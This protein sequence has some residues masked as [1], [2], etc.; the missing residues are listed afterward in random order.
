V[1]PGLR[2]AVVLAALVLTGAALTSAASAHTSASR[3]VDRTY[4]CAT[5]YLG[6]I[7]QVQLELFG[8]VRDPAGG[9]RLAYGEVTTTPNW[10]LAGLGP[11]WLEINPTHCNPLKAPGALTERGLQGGQVGGLGRIV[12]CQTPARLVI[13]IRGTFARPTAL[14]PHRIFDLTFLRAEAP[15]RVTTVA[16]S[17][18]KGRPIATLRVES[19]KAFLF[20]SANCEED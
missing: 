14:R 17:T 2:H 7:N 10:R 15:A 20:T 1:Q 12:D 11:S 4:A 3:T 8:R 6:G 13:R 18:S 16:L 9:D 19:G 5:G